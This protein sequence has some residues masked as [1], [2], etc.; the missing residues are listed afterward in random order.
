MVRNFQELSHRDLYELP[1]QRK[2]SV[3]VE[4]LTGGNYGFG[5]YIK[6]DSLANFDVRFPFI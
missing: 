3:G 4:R 5:T 1:F 6:N 2:L